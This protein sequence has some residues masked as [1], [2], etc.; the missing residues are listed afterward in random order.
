M[1]SSGSMTK[2][3]SGNKPLAESESKT[4]NSSPLTAQDV[5]RLV[6]EVL[7]EHSIGAHPELISFNTLLTRLPL[8]PRTAREEIKRGRIPSI[9]LPH[10]RRLLFDWRS[11]HEA[12]LR[13]QRNALE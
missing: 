12:L 13:H 8:S 2:T 7:R 3:N 1:A 6:E 11:V 5:R 10:A 9:R 4:D